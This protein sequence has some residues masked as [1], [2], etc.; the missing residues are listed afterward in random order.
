M[1]E[2][3]QDIREIKMLILEDLKT[4]N[5]Q[6]YLTFLKEMKQEINQ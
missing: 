2:T 1:Q 6:A 5:P 3:Y 4:E